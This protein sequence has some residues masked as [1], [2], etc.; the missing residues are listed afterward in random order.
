[1]AKIAEALG[2]LRSARARLLAGLASHIR[3]GTKLKPKYR[4][5][6]PATPTSKAVYRLIPQSDADIQAAALRAVGRLGGMRQKEQ[7]KLRAKVIADLTGKIGRIKK[8]IGRIGGFFASAFGGLK[9]AV[10][11]LIGRAGARPA[12]AHVRLGGMPKMPAA[13]GRPVSFGIVSVTPIQKNPMKAVSSSNVASVGW[14]PEE[15][16]THV[17]IMYI[18]FTNNWYYAYH[19]APLWLY[20]GIMSAGSK[21]RYVWQYIRRGLFPDGVPY[22]SADIEGYE[23]IDSSGRPFGHTGK[24]KQIPGLRGRRRGN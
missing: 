8:A 16:N 12:S 11:K 6:R 13:Q 2:G 1:M 10:D 23:R 20:Q 17:G 14:E 5:I 3:G 22:G 19:N 7:A 24:I 21:G 9:S 15:D 4:L 18:L